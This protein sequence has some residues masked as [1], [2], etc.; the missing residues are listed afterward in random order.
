MNKRKCTKRNCDCTFLDIL[1]E[2]PLLQQRDA[3]EWVDEILLSQY[4]RE[5]QPEKENPHF[6]PQPLEGNHPKLKKF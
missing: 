4:G 3:Q 2:N 5:Q 6:S 1:T